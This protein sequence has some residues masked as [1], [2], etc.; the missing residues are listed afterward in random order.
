MVQPDPP[1]DVLGVNELIK[2]RRRWDA[3]LAATRR[4]W[5]TQY[6]TAG[7]TP[8]PDTPDGPDPVGNLPAV[9]P[10]DLDLTRFDHLA[11]QTDKLTEADD[12]LAQPPQSSRWIPPQAPPGQTR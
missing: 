11:E 2:A 7:R 1:D 6:P 12:E 3:E 10:D 9:D 5:D 8:V 4:R